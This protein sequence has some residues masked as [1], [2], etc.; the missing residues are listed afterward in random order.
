MLILRVRISVMLILVWLV[1]SARKLEIHCAAFL[2]YF[3]R[4]E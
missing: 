2:G 1:P 3:S 4:E